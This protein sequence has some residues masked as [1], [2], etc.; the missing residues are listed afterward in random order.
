[1][2]TNELTAGSYV[3]GYTE[4]ESERLHDQARTVRDLL[5]SDTRYPEGSKVLEA[6]CGVGAQTVTLARNS[7]GALI[8]AMD[9]SAAQLEQARSLA[10]SEGIDTVRFMQGDIGKL[11]FDAESFDHVFVCYVLEHL[12]R[13]ADALRSLSAVLKPGGT[14][15]V[16]EGDHGSCYFHPETEEGLR[17]WRCLIDVQASLGGDSLIGRRLYPLLAEAGV[18]DVTVSPRM[19]YMDCSLPLLMDGFVRKTIVPMVQG[20]KDKALSMDMMNEAGWEKGIADLKAIADRADG[21]FVY[22]F[23]KAVGLK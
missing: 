16:I 11:P 17:A 21:S 18:R 9:I 5:H 6:G 23:F 19:V 15:T 8:T 1:M 10:A 4:R 3:H 2:Q 12:N 20:V 13:P 14:I 7:P 22:T